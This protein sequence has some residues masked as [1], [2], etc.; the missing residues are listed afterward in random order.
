MFGS[1]KACEEN[2]LSFWSVG[3]APWLRSSYKADIRFDKLQ[4]LKAWCERVRERPSVQKALAAEG[5][6]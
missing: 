2:Q 3:Q 1:S 6:R 5:L 4:S